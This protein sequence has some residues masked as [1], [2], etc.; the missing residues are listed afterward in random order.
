MKETGL[1]PF[2]RKPVIISG[3][4]FPHLPIEECLAIWGVK[5]PRV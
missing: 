2:L 4:S 3:T 1:E 5:S